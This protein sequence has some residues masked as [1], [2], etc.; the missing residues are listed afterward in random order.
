MG[1]YHLT[2]LKSFSS[3]LL[4]E[5]KLE[6]RDNK[7]ASSQN[8]PMHSHTFLPGAT[9]RAAKVGTPWKFNFQPGVDNKRAKIGPL[10]A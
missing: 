3:P 2:L 8:L 4:S 7:L 10:K 5:S 9:V 1:Q 6:T